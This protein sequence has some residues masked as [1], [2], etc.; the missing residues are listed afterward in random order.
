MSPSTGIIFNN[1]MDDFSAPNITNAYGLPPSPYNHIRPGKRP[2]SSMVPTIIV[3]DRSG[4]VRLAIG[5]TG[6]TRITTGVALGESLQVFQ[7][8]D[9]YCFIV[10]FNSCN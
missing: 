8:R 1:E 2:I 4:R 5:G 10:Q 9:S 7:M 6:G 3:D